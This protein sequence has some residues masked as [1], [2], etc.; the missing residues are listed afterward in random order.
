[1]VHGARL[2]VRATG[3]PCFC[4]PEPP[5]TVGDVTRHHD[6]RKQKGREAFAEHVH[7]SRMLKRRESVNPDRCTR[8]A[9]HTS[10]RQ[11][12]TR[13]VFMTEAQRLSAEQ[14][15]GAAT[16]RERRRR[17]SATART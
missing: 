13:G 12:D 15:A 5:G 9:S 16:G 7:I 14:S 8:R 3:H 6:D 4:G 11:L 17:L 1:V 2:F 10:R